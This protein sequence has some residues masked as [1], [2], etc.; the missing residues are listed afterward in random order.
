[1]PKNIPRI[2][3]KVLIVTNTEFILLKLFKSMTFDV[4]YGPYKIVYLCLSSFITEFSKTVQLRRA[5]I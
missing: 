4:L 5:I 2:N 3:N 1:M